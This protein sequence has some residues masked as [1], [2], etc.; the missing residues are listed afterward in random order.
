MGTQCSFFIDMKQ[1]QKLFSTGNT[2]YEEKAKGIIYKNVPVCR[3]ISSHVLI[4]INGQKPLKETYL[5][6][7]QT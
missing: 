3:Q 6:T 4:S 1:D 5:N 7:Y 2:F